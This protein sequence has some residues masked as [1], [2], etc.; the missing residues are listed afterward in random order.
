MTDEQPAATRRSPDEAFSALG[1]ET[2]VQI[3]REFGAADD[4]LAFSEVYDRVDLTDS[5][6]FNYHLDKLLGH[7][8]HKVDEQYA[9]ARPGE[10]I[11]EAIHSGAVT[12][13]PQLERTAVDQHC[14][15]CDRDLAI[16]WRNGSVEVFCATCE[17]RW[18]QPWGRVGG[19]ESVGEGYL[20]RL[21]FPPAG[22]EN[23]SPTDIYRSAQTWVDLEL[24]AVSAGLCPRC[25][26]T[27]D[28]N[29]YVCE[30]HDDAGRCSTCGKL[31]AVTLVATCTNCIYSAGTGALWGLLGSPELLTYL[32]DH[33]LNPFDPEQPNRLDTVLNEYEERIL[34]T[35]PLEFE[36]VVDAGSE[37]LTLHVD[38]QLN[39]LEHSQ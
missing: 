16:Q 8:V 28:R 33:D 21:P 2:R 15:D 37:P 3:L 30:D 29:L 14:S 9:L 4:P 32:F 36:F 1:N 39:I 38:D 11:I 26:A 35:D 24:A 25:S 13:D 6:Q 19:P 27:V 10:R 34:A 23:R 22:L 7:F 5:A 12:D 17:S 18:D 31:F 20:G